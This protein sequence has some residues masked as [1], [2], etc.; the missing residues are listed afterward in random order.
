M[1]YAMIG[2]II[3]GTLLFLPA[4]YVWW[5]RIKAPGHAADHNYESLDGPSSANN[6]EP[7][8]AALSPSQAEQ[9]YNPH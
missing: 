6:H 4:L 8:P 5:F 7:F 2:G 1:A 9:R 3:V